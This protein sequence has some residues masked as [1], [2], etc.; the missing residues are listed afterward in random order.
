MLPG[1]R[2]YIFW[3]ENVE[4]YYDAFDAVS[5][6]Y[7]WK[8]SFFIS[9]KFIYLNPKNI[10]IQVNGS[11]IFKFFSSTK[12]IRHAIGGGGGGGKKLVFTQD[13]LRISFPDWLFH[14]VKY[15][16]QT[17]LIFHPYRANKTQPTRSGHY[18]EAR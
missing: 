11:S 5:Q 7:C 16:I 10:L 12:R 17:V 13:P 4:F 3:G 14:V 8:I 2:E 1:R 6:R 15:F 18:G 9:T